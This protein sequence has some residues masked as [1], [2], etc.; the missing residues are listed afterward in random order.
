MNE[1][2]TI[3]ILDSVRFIELPP[4]RRKEIC[5]ALKIG[6]EA[7]REKAER[8]RGCEFCKGHERYP[9]YAGYSKQYDVDKFD[10]REIEEINFCPN[11]GRELKG[12]E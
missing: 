9:F 10:E 4:I 11:C 8:S 1:I 12:G 7:L 2:K 3:A 5:D 6:M